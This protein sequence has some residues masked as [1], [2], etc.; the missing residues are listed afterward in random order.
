MTEIKLDYGKSGEYD[1]V[2]E[3]TRLAYQQHNL[4][5][6]LTPD[7]KAEIFNMSKFRHDDNTYRFTKTLQRIDRVV[8]LKTGKE[9]IK[10]YYLYHGNTPNDQPHQFS[11]W[12]ELDTHKEPIVNVS[13][14]TDDRGTRIR[15]VEQTGERL[16]YHEPFNEQIVMESLKDAV[17]IGDTYGVQLKVVTNPESPE[18]IPLDS[19]Y[20]DAFIHKS[21]SDLRRYQNTG[22][23]IFLQLSNAS[24]LINILERF[25]PNDIKTALEYLSKSATENTSIIEQQ[26]TTKKK[27]Q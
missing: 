18:D 17:K 7:D 19:I 2:H 9:Y 23:P 10:R 20:L 1:P 26:S 21:Y 3:K 4:E 14:R 6:R 5:Y 25:K 8:D 13:V 24:T 11:K 16:V 15:D 22:D 27:Q 12:L